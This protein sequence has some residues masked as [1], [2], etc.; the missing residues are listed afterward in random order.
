MSKTYKLI[1][2]LNKLTNQY[3]NEVDGLGNECA[4]TDRMVEDIVELAKKVHK[5]YIKELGE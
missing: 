5:A 2:K 3:L 1:K 4:Y